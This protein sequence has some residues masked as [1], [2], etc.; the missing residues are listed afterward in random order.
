MFYLFEEVGSGGVL[1]VS[2]FIKVGGR[3]FVPKF[4]KFSFVWDKVCEV[5]DGILVYFF[6]EN[7]KVWFFKVGRF[8]NQVFVYSPNYS[9]YDSNEGVGFPTVVL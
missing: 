1:V 6:H 4:I 5:F 9:G 7:F 2:K 8:I 3:V